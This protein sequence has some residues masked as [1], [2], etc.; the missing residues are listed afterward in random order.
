MEHLI[1]GGCLSKSC[2]SVGSCGEGGFHERAHVPPVLLCQ[3]ARLCEALPPPG[4]NEI[5]KEIMFSNGVV[6][7]SD[8]MEA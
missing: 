8:L 2:C 6:M 3:R 4:M 7:V 1:K 5:G